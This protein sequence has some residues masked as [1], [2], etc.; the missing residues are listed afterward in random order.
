MQST[1]QD[2]NPI[3]TELKPGVNLLEASAGTGKTYAIAMLALRFVVE[4]NYT[5]DQLLIVTFTKAATKELKERVRARLVEAKQFLTGQLPVGL[6]ANISTWAE[7]LLESTDIDQQLAVQRLNNALLSID[8]AG[9]FTIHGFCQRLLKEHA[10]ES[11][12]MFDV[13]LSDETLA[14]RQQMVEDFWRSQIYP[15]NAWEVSLLC[16]LYD[17]PDKLMA[18]LG[19]YPATLTI[20]PE[21]EDL[22]DLL[23]ALKAQA[24]LAKTALDQ[25]GE[26]IIAAVD[27]D[28]FK[29]SFTENFAEVYQCLNQWLVATVES[30]EHFDCPCPGESGFKFLSGDNLA[31]E[32][33]VAHKG[34]LDFDSTTFDLLYVYS[35]KVSL[36]LRRALAEELQHN[37]ETRLLQLNI[38]SHDSLITRTAEALSN[39]GGELLIKAIKQQYHVALIDEFQDTDQNQWHI[40][41]HLFADPEQYLYLIGDPKQA[42]YKFRGADIHSYLEAKQQAKNHYT[43]GHNWRSH[44][45][46]VQAINQLFSLTD[47]PFVFSGLEFNPVKPA[48]DA[49]QG[50][51]MQNN[52][53]LAP[54]V[55]WQL[56]ESESTSGYWT[57]GK[58]AEEIKRAVTNEILYLLQGE[59]SIHSDGAS[60]AIRAADIAILVRT[61]AQAALYQQILKQAGIPAVINSTDSVFASSEALDLY[62]LMQALAQPADINLLKQALS[63]SWFAMDGQ[64][65][66]RTLSDEVQLGAW[67]SRFQDYHE[68][69]Q[70]KGFM[71]MML[72]F[73][74][75]ENVRVHLTRTAQAERQ[76]T[77]L[78]HLLELVQQASLDEHLG[79]LKSIAWLRSAITAENNPNDEQQLRLESDSDAVKIVTM[80]R[81]KGLE[82]PIVFCPY[83]WS[84]SDRL[85]KEQLTLTCHAEGE[86]LVDLGSDNFAQHRDIAL[87]EELA[88]DLRILYVALTRAKYRCYISWVDSRSKHK[89]NQSAL[90]YLLYAQADIAFT[91]QQEILQQLASDYPASFAYQ[92]LQPGNG[93]NGTYQV[94][95]QGGNLTI[96]R[97]KRHLYSNWQMSS[98]TALSYLSQHEA[99]E[100]PLDK[101]EEGN[102]V[103]YSIEQ[104]P[105]ALAK[106]AHTGNVIH[107]L[108]ENIS[109]TTLAGREEISQQ[110]DAACQRYGLSVDAPEII[111]ELLYHA[112][113][114]P[115][116]IDDSEFYLANINEKS[117]LKEMPFYLSLT[118]FSTDKINEILQQH[119][120]FQ[121]L[122]AKQMQGYLT[123]FIDLIFVYQG[124]YYV[125]DYKSNTLSDYQP[126]SLTQAMREH[127]YGLQYWLYS[128]VLHQYLQQRLPAYQFAE[129]FG[130]VRYL[131][132]RGMQAEQATSGVYS[133]L[134]DEQRIS[135][136]TELFMQG[137]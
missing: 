118:E 131:F 58:A 41:A 105:I 103:S 124:R 127:N 33:R 47:N 39:Q 43:L 128:V 46:L 97:Q 35:Q 96:P 90:A 99:A 132:V 25:Q 19:F 37:L 27:S 85:Q 62:K 104:A 71:A 80:H 59:V 28:Y 30:T 50:T 68:L 52:Q 61:N 70:K 7:A 21:L 24:L 76:I 116:S 8:Q 10:L 102:D 55:L 16:H 73:L 94:T 32:I 1:K 93:L 110:R 56:A 115:L 63:L 79:L 14:V 88:E 130:G 11:G 23:V 135:L 134:P 123:G 107:D 53:P 12:Q 18:S 15:R 119:P 3:A 67:L 45:D 29:K 121:P 26:L 129:H 17:T 54:L 92:L 34:K 113:T 60:H 122:S 20:Y 117:C 49:A 57:N 100:L 83:L 101:A 108:L 64:Q 112:V 95:E 84:R 125:L 51:L 72:R 109:F 78:H 9:I 89:P 2:F 42:I 98:Y 82:Y 133:D 114:T 75:Q 74:S 137:G 36:T 65:L 126:E 136:L 81:S 69:W 40:F 6:D 106:G 87:Q 13:E 48:L 77:N 120:A 31:K 111:N 91:Q 66:Y 86:M 44:P 38:M 5:I 22:D 4:Q